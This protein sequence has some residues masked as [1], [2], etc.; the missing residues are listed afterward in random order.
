MPARA[1]E[2]AWATPTNKIGKNIRQELKLM[3]SMSNPI[4]SYLILVLFPLLWIFLSSSGWGKVVASMGTTEARTKGQG[5]KVENETIAEFEP[6]LAIR[7][8]ACITCHARIRS[9][10]ITDFGYGDSYFWGAP[11]ESGSL[12]PFNGSIYGD[13]YG[14]EPNKTAWGTAQID[15][16]IIVP[17]TRFAFNLRTAAGRDLASQ[18][19]Y[20][21]ALDASSLAQYLRAVENQKPNPSTVIEKKRVFIGAPDAATLEARF[22]IPPGSETKLKY[23]KSDAKTSPDIKGIGFSSS[24]GYFT[25]AREVECDGDLFVR[26][27]LFLNHAVISTQNGCRIY[28]TGPIFLQDEVEYKNSN[29]SADR[30]NLQLVS[31]KAIFL[32]VGDKS[33]DATD[34]DS[35]LSRRLVSGYAIST[36]YTRDAHS[37]S[38]PPKKAGQS[39]YD[40]GKLI[41]S[42]EDASCRDSAVSFSRLLLNAPQV[43]SRYRGKFAG[44]VIAE[45]ALFRPGSSD[46][47][48]DPVFREVPV[49]PILR[50]TDYLRVE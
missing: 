14:A 33:C 6:A 5:K 28:A 32:G 1:A 47:V 11:G 7:G 13:F 25:N 41:P 12:G 46:F 44:L 37:K 26:G 38:I 22:K 48:F 8:S 27:A 10:I 9:T 4:K 39:I 42:L 15:G 49:L 35:P 40:Q 19:A 2:S 43:H 23:V 17:K 3:K 29:N 24:G 18:P 20:R 34:K 21:Q 36:F 50:D 30:A 31:A 45:I 16:R